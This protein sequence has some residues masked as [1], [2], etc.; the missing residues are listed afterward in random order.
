MGGG[1]G[2]EV[3]L[4]LMMRIEQLHYFQWRVSK[5]VKF[6]FERIGGGVPSGFDLGEM[7]IF[8]DGDY[9]SSKKDKR[10]RMMVY[11][12]IVNLI[13]SLLRLRNKKKIEFFSVDSSF[14]FSLYWRDGG[15]CVYSKG[16]MLGPFKF[17]EILSSVE[18]GVVRFINDGNGLAKDD[19]V[20][21]DL[22]GALSDL[23]LT[24]E[25]G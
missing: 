7:E 14:S 15:V 9:I 10:L 25:R 5:L 24:I 16:V 8:S 17:Y 2:S 23:R 13:D 18:M 1:L 6:N 21:H 12:S 4:T 20:S 19:A 22:D 3:L 11:L